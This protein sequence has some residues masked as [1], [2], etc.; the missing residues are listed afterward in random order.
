VGVAESKLYP[1]RD[2]LEG[3]YSVCLSHALTQPHHPHP[4][5]LPARGRGKDAVPLAK[6]TKDEALPSHPLACAMASRFWARLMP[7]T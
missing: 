2:K 3:R 1:S 4:S 6:S 5:P 7:P